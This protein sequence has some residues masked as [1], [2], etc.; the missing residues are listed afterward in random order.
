MLQQQPGAIECMSCSKCLA[1]NILQRIS[2]RIAHA[3]VHRAKHRSQP[4]HA[5]PPSKHLMRPHARGVTSHLQT[6]KPPP[7]CRSAP[8][9][10]PGTTWG[11][12]GHHH[13][14][15]HKCAVLDLQDL[16]RAAHQ[17]TVHEAN[18][19]G[20]AA[21]AQLLERVADACGALGV[22]CVLPGHDGGSDGV[23]RLGCIGRGHVVAP[24]VSEP[25][26]EGVIA[27]GGHCQL[28]SVSCGPHSLQE[29]DDGQGVTA[30]HLAGEVRRNAS[31]NDGSSS[32]NVVGGDHESVS[33]SRQ[34]QGACKALRLVE[35]LS[36]QLACPQD[37]AQGGGDAGTI[38]LIGVHHVGLHGLVLAQ[39]LGEDGGLQAVSGAGPEEPLRDSS[40]AGAGGGG[41]DE[42]HAGLGSLSHSGQG[43][44]GADLTDDDLHTAG[45]QG[46]DSCRGLSSG[47]VGSDGGEVDAGC[48][49]QGGDSGLLDALTNALQGVSSAE[50]P[51]EA[52]LELLV[53]GTVLEQR[54][55]A[56]WGRRKNASIGQAHA[57]HSQHQGQ[58]APSCDVLHVAVR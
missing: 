42:Q 5:A 55:H 35:G 46:L 2:D 31:L 52:Q 10:K 44:G 33:A 15:L 19:A 41:G 27:C 25:A 34:V 39:Q 40:E 53:A 32:C 16:V 14:N 13:A 43:G 57:A 48:G 12:V 20:G 30:V 37:L 6:Y 38:G 4:T 50:G 29:A 28:E 1:A 36:G 9:P 26:E 8:P 3:H 17:V 7:S 58:Q 45:S 18:G 11:L 51:D 22:V 49:V 47:A 24:H 23:V 56:P 21:E 54:A